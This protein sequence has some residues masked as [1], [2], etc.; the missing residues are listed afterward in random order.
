MFRHLASRPGLL[1]GCAMERPGPFYHRTGV[2]SH[3][4]PFREEFLDDADGLPVMGVIKD[5]NDYHSVP[6]IEVRVTCPGTVRH[7]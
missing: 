5:R 4:R 6:D 2:Y 1:L 3:Y 7:R